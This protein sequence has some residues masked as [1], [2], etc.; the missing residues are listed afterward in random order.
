MKIYDESIT[1]TLQMT[2]PIRADS[3]AEVEEIAE[4]V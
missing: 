4:E 3:L 1:E 2:V